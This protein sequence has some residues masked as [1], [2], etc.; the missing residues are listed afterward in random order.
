MNDTPRATPAR[1]P[2]GQ[3]G[4]RLTVA[5]MALLILALTLH[6][7]QQFAVILQQLLI[8]TFI[9]Y[10]I[11]PVHNWLVKHRVPRRVSFVFLVILFLA[12]SYGLG[13]MIYDSVSELTAN[14]PQY[15]ANLSWLTQ[16]TIERV[17]GMD[18]EL[19]QQIIMGQS[20][21]VETGV[22]MFRTALGTF[23]NFFTQVLVV[24]VF[25][26][27][28]LAE[29][30]SF[31]R[32][33]MAA[34]EPDRATRIMAVLANINQSIVRYIAVKTLVSLLVG[35][36]TG[37]VLAIF[38]VN[39]PVLWGI[40]AFLLNYIPYLGSMVATL[41][42]AILALV[43]LPNPW[44]VALLVLTL[45]FIHN[46]TGYIVEPRMAGRQLN[47]SPLVI[48]LALSFGGA[49]WGIVGMILAVP[50]VVAI[51]AVLE[52]IQETKPLATM[53]SHL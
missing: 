6:L 11:L 46:F 22:F 18:R 12:A 40:V 31:Q 13:Q 4:H 34:F 51:K 27:F 43:E 30:A 37:L 2:G 35:V 19:L 14:L 52:N 23:F 24:L 41:L 36:L 26:A 39:F 53:M 42:P 32:R 48:L 9:G 45:G 50:V 47:L 33:I 28:L 5:A 38:G 8:A 16:Q 1:A 29:Q 44:R 25:L 10:L 3:F 15:Q 21:T 17:P 7:M 20:A 49:I